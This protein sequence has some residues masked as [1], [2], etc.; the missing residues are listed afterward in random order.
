MWVKICGMTTPEAVEAA[1]AAGV[2]ALGFVFAASPRRVTPAEAARLAQPARGRA[3]CVAVTRQPRQEELAEI[4]EV[5]EPDILQSDAQNLPRLRLPAQL[6]LL[7][8]LRGAQQPQDALP[9]RV[10]FE[11]PAS[12]AGVRCDW[13]AA[14]ATARRT[15]LVL[16]GGLDADNVGAAIAQVRP[17]GVDVSSGVE[18]RPGVKSPEAIAR[19]AAAARDAFTRFAV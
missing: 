10:L 13:S 6:A 17:F 8:V 18:E 12:G 16:A 9:A 5:F 2:Q 15:Q 11:G 3:A 7:P 1:L 4:L 14:Q 19:F